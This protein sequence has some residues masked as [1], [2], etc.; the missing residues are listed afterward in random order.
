MWCAADYLLPVVHQH[1]IVEH[2]DVSGLHQFL[3][4]EM[5]RFKDDVSEVKSF[6]S[7]KKVL[8]KTASAVART[9]SDEKPKE[10]AGAPATNGEQ[11]KQERLAT[12]KLELAKTLADDGK[13]DK[14]RIRFEDILKMY[15][16]TRAAG[17]AKVLLDKMNK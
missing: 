17:E 8:P 1:A 16:K 12:N 13:V 14:A 3:P 11:E 5:R 15:P 6:L 9:S 7:S 10:E 2:R 4:F